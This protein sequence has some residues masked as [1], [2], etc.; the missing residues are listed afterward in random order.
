LYEVINPVFSFFCLFYV[1]VY[2]GLLVNVFVVT[3]MPTF[4][5]TDYSQVISYSVIRQQ[6][7]FIS[8][9]SHFFS[10]NTSPDVNHPISGE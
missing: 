10:L 5:N 3:L 1:A 7:R 4:V 6:T 2:F 8:I 9:K